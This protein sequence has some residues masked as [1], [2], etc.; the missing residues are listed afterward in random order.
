M[1]HMYYCIYDIYI[2]I[3]IYVNHREVGSRR[4]HAGD[5]NRTRAFL[6]LYIYL[7]VYT[8]TSISRYL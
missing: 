4:A 7:Y 8:Y 1:W 5:C 2:C 6:S 3:F